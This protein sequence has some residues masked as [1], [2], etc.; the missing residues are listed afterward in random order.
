M[1][2]LIAEFQTFWQVS[3][4]RGAGQN[5]DSLIERDANGLPYVSGKTIKGLFR[6]SFA[7]LAEWQAD[8]YKQHHDELFGSFSGNRH[9]TLQGKLH[10]SS[11]TF[12]EQEIEDFKNN[13]QL[14]PLLATTHTSTKIDDKGVA[15]NKSLRSSEVALPVILQGEISLMENADISNE[16]LTEL[17]TNASSLITNIGSKKNRGYGQVKLI[18]E[19]KK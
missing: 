11:L 9:E 14:I 10:F 18:L 8:D 15:V 2:K 16:K 12:S 5:L 3:T 4:G 7:K 13:Q 17:L 1:I 19:E 6:E